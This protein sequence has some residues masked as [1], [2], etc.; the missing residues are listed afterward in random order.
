[1]KVICINPK[2]STKLIKGGIY[3]AISLQPRYRSTN[4]KSVHIKN[5]G[6]YNALNFTTLDGTELYNIN[7]F[8]GEETTYL[9][10]SKKD[11]TGHFVKCRY[12]SGKSLK[13]NE[14]YYVEKQVGIRK[15]SYNGSFYFV[16][17]FKIRGVKNPVDPYNFY[18]IPITEQRNIK[19]LLSLDPPLQYPV[20]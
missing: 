6:T 14:I 4:E 11:Y 18:E 19:Q 10:A 3:T 8:N 15:K 9:D 16:Y 1:M 13:E 17:K 20:A 5:I 2:E 7:N 12:S